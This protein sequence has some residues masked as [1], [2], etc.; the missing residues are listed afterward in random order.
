MTAL[1]A[2]PLG[3]T[4]LKVSPIGLGCMQMAGRG[5]VERVYR[6]DLNQDA[7]TDVVKTARFGGI[8]WY[9]TAE[10]YGRGRADATL[11][12]ALQEINSGN[13][14]Q[15]A[16]EIVIATKWNP[17]LRTASTVKHGVDPRLRAIGA[18]ILHQI[19]W[20]YG[21]LSSRRAQLRAMATLYHEGEIH[22]VGI[23]NFN[24]RQMADA[25]ALLRA[26]GVPLASNQVRCSLLRRDIESNGVLEV[27]KELGI[28]LIAYF[29]LASGILTG[30]FHDHRGDLKYVTTPMRRWGNGLNRAALD[31]TAPLIAELRAVGDRY[32]MSAAQVALNWLVTYYGDTV[33]A[34]PGAST[35]YHASDNARAM[36][37]CLTVDERARL[38]ELS[39]RCA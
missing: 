38:A 5:F 3:A 37:F 4:T 36:T 15:A 34:I 26:E 7:A 32:Q 39:T 28:T 21:S 2:R 18:P 14:D 11:A 16:N 27:A 30:K 29:P 33:V 24:A 23:S 6:S 12:A 25:H 35:G 9:D 13:N 22:A 19:H 31:R 8:T 10:M 1:S 17:L 20:P